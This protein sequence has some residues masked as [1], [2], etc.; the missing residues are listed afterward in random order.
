MRITLIAAQNKDGLI[1]V[2]GK[3]PWHLPEDLQF[4]KNQTMNETVICG[5]KTWDSIPGTLPGRK[6]IV[7]SKSPNAL[8]K[9]GFWR[10]AWNKEEALGLALF[11]GAKEVYI[12]GGAS[13][14]EAFEP[15]AD[16][17]LLTE[18]DYDYEATTPE[19]EAT[20]THL[21]KAVTAPGRW[22]K[23]KTLFKRDLYIVVEWKECTC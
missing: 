7:L 5:R 16:R 2:N 21:P 14:Y 10:R 12:I 8:K 22:A 13:V 11:Q 1:G 4:F 6:V 3:M 23:E 17:L 9:Q 20:L 15:I 18:Y 19:E